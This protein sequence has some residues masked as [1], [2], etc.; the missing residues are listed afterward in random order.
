[1]SHPG[2]LPEVHLGLG[3]QDVGRQRQEHGAGRR[4]QGGLGGPVHGARQILK[5]VDLRRPLDEGP[6]DRRQVGPEDRLRDVEALIVLASRQQKR[7]P[8]LLGVVQ[9]AEGVAEAGRDVDVHDGEFPRSLGVAVGHRHD[10]RLLEP[11]HVTDAPL[12]HEAV[13]QRQLGGPRV[14]EEILHP[15]LAQ[16]LQERLL[17]GHERHR[18]PLYAPAPGREPSSPRTQGFADNRRRTPSTPRIGDDRGRP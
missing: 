13:H 2:G 3:V 12:G 1:V 17:P 6:G 15:L 11:E 9:H 16:E 18:S 7:R 14:P 8:R 4:R 10:R 5:P